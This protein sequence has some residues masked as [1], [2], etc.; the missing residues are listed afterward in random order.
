MNRRRTPPPWK[1]TAYHLDRPPYDPEFGSL[2]YAGQFTTR[3]LSGTVLAREFEKTNPKPGRYLL[4]G[5]PGP[6]D[7]LNPIVVTVEPIPTPQ[8]RVKVSSPC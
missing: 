1:V 6:V 3:D 5:G 7:N 8:V 2:R 4:I